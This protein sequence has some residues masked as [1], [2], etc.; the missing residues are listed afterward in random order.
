MAFNFS[1]QLFLLNKFWC[2]L[3]LI[4]NYV[5]IIDKS[6]G[7]SFCARVKIQSC[8]WF[9]CH[10]GGK[11]LVNVLLDEHTCLGPINWVI[12]SRS[13]FS[14]QQVQRI[15]FATETH[16]SSVQS[17]LSSAYQ[18]GARNT[19]T[20]AKC[21]RGFPPWKFIF[22]VNFLDAPLSPFRK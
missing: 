10:T 13:Q 12:M 18:H 14:A 17:Q 5:F 3:G 7:C 15:D 19:P 4:H 9:F 6:S 2:Y 11:L 16:F 8:S 20:T 21:S 1:W 22:C